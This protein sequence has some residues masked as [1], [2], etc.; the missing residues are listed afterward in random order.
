MTTHSIWKRMTWHPYRLWMCGYTEGSVSSSWLGL[1]FTNGHN[2]TECLT[3]SEKGAKKSLS[4]SSLRFYS[5]NLT[6]P[7]LKW[8]WTVT[9][10][11]FL[12]W[13]KSGTSQEFSWVQNQIRLGTAWALQ[14]RHCW[15]LQE[16]SHLA[17]WPHALGWMVHRSLSTAP[18]AMKINVSYLHNFIIFNQEWLCTS[19]IKILHNQL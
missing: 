4:G 8:N 13:L 18:T 17:Q 15:L 1:A 12:P 5:E 19:T 9:P 6:V 10:V 2:S 7:Y 3:S 16:C 11:G 14:E